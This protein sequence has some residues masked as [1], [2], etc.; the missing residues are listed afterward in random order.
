MKKILILCAF[1]VAFALVFILCRGVTL[2][3]ALCILFPLFLF[4]CPLLFM[5]P[6]E[7]EKTEEAKRED[8]GRYGKWY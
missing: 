1:I 8:E 2:I 6:K 5:K 3:I 7:E 4:Y